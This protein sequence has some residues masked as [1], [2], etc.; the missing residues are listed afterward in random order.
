MNVNK[1]QIRYPLPKECF[2]YVYLGNNITEEQRLEVK[3]VLKLNGLKAKI[4]NKNLY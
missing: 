1:Y 4:V 2:K 3:E